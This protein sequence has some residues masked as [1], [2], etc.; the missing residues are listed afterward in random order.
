MHD[1]RSCRSLIEEN[2][3]R[4]RTRET[5][6]SQMNKEKKNNDCTSRPVDRNKRMIETTMMK[7]NASDPVPGPTAHLISR[8]TQLN[9]FHRST[10]LGR[11]SIPGW[12]GGPGRAQVGV[13]RGAFHARDLRRRMLVDTPWARRGYFL[14]QPSRSTCCCLSR[15]GPARAVVSASSAGPADVSPSTCVLAAIQIPHS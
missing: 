13:R 14:K 9:V 8:L 3:R 6:K 4:K 1:Q 5:R 15:A 12:R 7:G 10:G 11:H 2:E